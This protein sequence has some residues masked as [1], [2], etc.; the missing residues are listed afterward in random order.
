[1][2]PEAAAA[3]A[4]SPLKTIGYLVAAKTRRSAT[5]AM[6]RPRQVSRCPGGRCLP[7]QPPFL[8]FPANF[9][10]PRLGDGVEG[11]TA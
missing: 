10:A 6:T 11:M 7:R 4:I 2:D 5:P 8:T 9:H 1:M 3:A